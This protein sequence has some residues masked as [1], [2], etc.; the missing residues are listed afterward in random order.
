MG[1]ERRAVDRVTVSMDP[2]KRTMVPRMHR[3]MMK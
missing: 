2:K 1:T 3:D